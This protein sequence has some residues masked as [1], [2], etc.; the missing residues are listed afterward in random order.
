V[1]QT[2]W[3]FWIQDRVSAKIWARVRPLA[4]TPRTSVIMLI[5]IFRHSQSCGFLHFVEI[6]NC[7]WAEVGLRNII[8]SCT[9]LSLRRR[10][11]EAKAVQPLEQP[12]HRSTNHSLSLARQ[13][14]TEMPPRMLAQ[15]LVIVFRQPCELA[16]NGAS[17]SWLRYRASTCIMSTGFRISRPSKMVRKTRAA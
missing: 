12:Y 6:W 17:P 15:T 11:P 4:T 10:K 1:E 14:I 16:E 7:R 2:S 8:Y 13:S 5:D 9:A 3:T